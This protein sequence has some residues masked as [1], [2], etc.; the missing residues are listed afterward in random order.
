M[1]LNCEIFAIYVLT[2]NFVTPIPRPLCI[3]KQFS[4]LRPKTAR[5]TPFNDAVWLYSHCPN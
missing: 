3:I 1:F 2:C 5:T 4:V